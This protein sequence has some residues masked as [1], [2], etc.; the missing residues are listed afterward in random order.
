MLKEK[1]FGPIPQSFYANECLCTAKSMLA[2]ANEA[3]LLG[4]PAATAA[5]K[6]FLVVA[7]QISKPDK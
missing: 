7:N 2:Y 3:D 4:Q 6:L 5:Q 1:L